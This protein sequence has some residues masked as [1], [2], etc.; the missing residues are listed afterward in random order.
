MAR[1]WAA[2]AVAGH[3]GVLV[4]VGD[5]A[6]DCGVDVGSGGTGDVDRV[7][8]AVFIGVLT[9]SAMIPAY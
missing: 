6:R 4:V 1:E 5:D 3:C 9:G 8:G 7:G 2:A